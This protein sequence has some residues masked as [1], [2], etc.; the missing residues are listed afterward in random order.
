MLA[1]ALGGLVSASINKPFQIFYLL[2]ALP[3]LFVLAAVMFSEG[4]AKPPWLKGVWVLFVAAGLVP[5]GAWFVHS[6]SAGIAP[7]LDAEH[8]SASLG[9]ALRAQHVQGPVATLATQYVPDAG[10]EIDR[11][12]AAGPFMYRTRGFVSAE[13]AREW[14]IVTRDDAGTLAEQPPGAIVT[15]DYPDVQPAQEMELAGQAAALGYRPAAKAGGFTIWVRVTN[16]GSH[17][18]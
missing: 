17:A 10:A 13:Q 8:R 4:E 1:A 18:E 12:F 5:V 6:A 3:P 14:R 16:G 7:A 15:G 11:R 2:P 9:A